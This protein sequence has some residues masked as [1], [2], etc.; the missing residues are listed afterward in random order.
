MEGVVFDIKRFAIHDGGGIRST[1]FLKGCLLHCPWCQNPEGLLR[2]VRLWCHPVSCV[3][4]GTCMARCP[5]DAIFLDARVHID[6][7][8]CTTCSLCVEVCPAAALSLDGW[9]ISAEAAAALLLR[10]RP[11]FGTDGGVTLSGGEVLMQPLFAQEILRLCKEA[12]V[13]TAIETSLSGSWNTLEGFLPLVDHFIIDIKYMDS[14]VHEARLGTS[15]DVILENHGRLVHA[16]ADVL[17]RTPLIPGYTATEENIRAIA[18]HVVAVDP[19]A[20]Y[21]LLNFNPLCRS[22]YVALE[23]DYPV[24]GE[25]LT[26]ERMEAFY[27]ILQH[28]GVRNIIKE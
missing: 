10:D 23:Q 7:D 8:R 14:L 21:E 19:E 5:E 22:K 16:G 2:T 27:S 25:A 12:G 1:L 18:R 26:T 17:V 11:F 3:R 24:E 28:E 20:K 13:D 4:C 9:V 6:P 15:N